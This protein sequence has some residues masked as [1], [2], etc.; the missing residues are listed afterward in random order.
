MRAES[1]VLVAG[2]LRLDLANEQLWLDGEEVPLQTKPFL[3]LR[4]L[5]RHP[6]QL[7]SKR[8]LIEAGWGDL[9]VSDAVLTT[10]IK[11][12]R[13]AL[14][15]SA[16]KPYAVENVHGRGYRF[17]LEVSAEASTAAR[18]AIKGGG[19]GPAASPA[20]EGGAIVGTNAAGAEPAGA[21]T[22]GAHLDVARRPLVLGALL[23]VVAALSLASW[24]FLRGAPGDAAAPVAGSAPAPDPEQA[25][26]QAAAGV[27]PERSIAVLPLDDFSP[28]GDAAWFADGLAE[29]ILNVLARSPDLQVA[30]RTSSSRYRD[31]AVDAREIAEALGVA[32]LLEGSV[33]SAGDQ[34]RITLQLIRAEDGLHVFSESWNRALSIESVFSVQQE[35][36]GQVL[37]ALDAAL[38]A[39]GAVAGSGAPDLDFETYSDYL[40]AKELKA[41]RDPEALSEALNLLRGVVD[42]APGYGP[43]YASL[44]TA[45]L[46]GASYAGVP[47]EEARARAVSNIDTALT[48]APDNGEAHNAAALLAL[49]EGDSEGALVHADRAVALSP[50]LADAH[51]RRGV[52]LNNL[53][54]F[55]DAEEALR[56]A[57]LLDPLSSIRT[58]AIMM[59]YLQKGDAAAALEAARRNLRWNPENHVALGGMG[60]VLMEL[61]DY[62]Q[63]HRLLREAVERSPSQLWN[64]HYF[65]ALLWRVGLDEEIMALEQEL[66][67]LAQGAVLAAR[68]DADT[69]VALVRPRS[70][71]P[72]L[73]LTPLSVLYWAGGAQEAVDAA[74]EQVNVL[75]L[76]HPEISLGY[77]SEPAQAIAI[78]ESVGDPRATTLRDRLS[79]FFGHWDAQAEYVG[80]TTLY[81]AAAW[82]MLEGDR[83]QALSLLEDAARRGLVFRELLLDPLF[84]ELREN[85]RFVT[86]ISVMEET[87]GQARLRVSAAQPQAQAPA[88]GRR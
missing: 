25:E 59:N 34:L 81:A 5:M 26:G 67:W 55:A 28:N 86:V 23:A 31:V 84:G 72:S 54:R 75:H 58:H 47:F 24:V 68:G 32:Y 19:I 39:P 83:E 45:W 80:G 60:Q 36:S 73:G 29:E 78:L 42:R 20:A 49:M 37:R 4:E 56:R 12:L 2:A 15:D 40:R 62:A 70:Q 76:T 87:A 16:R 64:H 11:E 85:A 65:G 61:G 57:S 17:L 44:A 51:Y 27:V 8:D 50:S 1:T 71:E 9:P 21:G 18:E 35:V 79:N 46:L 7:V 6:R 38:G 88:V 63:A 52:T 30:S 77:R 3:L 82:R 10:A 22:A 33:R 41:T 43:A 53:G 66:Y 69:A 14:S 48:L 13:K 74:R